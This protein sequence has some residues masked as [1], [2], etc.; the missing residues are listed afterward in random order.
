M[1]GV[2]VIQGFFSRMCG[3]A[4]DDC[5]GGGCTACFSSNQKALLDSLI[6]FKLNHILPER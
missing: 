3:K 2:E 4:V 5:E 1:K 6:T